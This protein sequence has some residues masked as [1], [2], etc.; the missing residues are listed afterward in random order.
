MKFWLATLMVGV[1][2]VGCDS[3]GGASS[4]RETV[5]G[6]WLM[7]TELKSADCFDYSDTEST[8]GITRTHFLGIED[9]GS[10]FRL[11][12]MNAVGQVTSSEREL[13]VGQDAEWGEGRA[14]IMELEDDSKVMLEVSSDWRQIRADDIEY[15]PP[16]CTSARYDLLLNRLEDSAEIR[17]ANERAKA[18]PL[19]KDQ[20][21]SSQTFLNPG[22]YALYNVSLF[23]DDRQ[24]FK[25]TGVS[26][27]YRLRLYHSSGRLR[28]SG[29]ECYAEGAQASTA[30]ISNWG[31]MTSGR[32]YLLVQSTSL[33]PVDG[34]FTLEASFQPNPSE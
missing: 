17:F 16:G 26:D 22:Q 28:A 32:H 29:D 24:S 8:V 12:L 21:L 9:K 15:I 6:F 18:R 1:S 19:N 13:P 7:K 11:E 33:E 31:V 23:D 10:F 30:C 2:L 27:Q 25:V 5:E 20:T 34:S 4:S 3:G 14:L